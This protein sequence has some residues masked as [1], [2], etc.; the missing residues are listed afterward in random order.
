[1]LNRLVYRCEEKKVTGNEI[2]TFGGLNFFSLV[3]LSELK[4]KC[5]T[6]GFCRFMRISKDRWKW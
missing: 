5:V 6:I 2:D 1:M 4:I 3:I